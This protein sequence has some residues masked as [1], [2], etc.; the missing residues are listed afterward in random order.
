M[1]AR[2]G[3]ISFAVVGENGSLHG[4][5]ASR[6]SQMASTIKVM[7]LTAYLRHA[8]GRNLQDA[9]R[10]LVGWLRR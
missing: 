1:R 5:R 9:A 6:T 4:W 2:A 3:E 7:F 10:R 8:A